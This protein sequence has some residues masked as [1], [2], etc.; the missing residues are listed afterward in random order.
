MYPVLNKEFGNPIAFV[1][2]LVIGLLGGLA[3]ALHE[4]KRY[5]RLKREHFL[6]R[7]FKNVTIY[8][9]YFAIIVALVIAFT[10]GIS[11]KQGL[12][13]YVIGPEYSQFIFHGDYPIIVAYALF[14]CG[15]VS[16]TLI[17]SKKVES[18]V[19]FNMISGRY[20]KPIE[21]D[22]I[23]MSI[24]LNDSTHIA[25]ELGEEKFFSFL[26]RFYL[27]LSPAI[28]AS[29]GQI[30]RYVGD[31]VIISW[32]V[33]SAAENTECLRTYF[34]AK[35]I[36]RRQKEYYLSNWGRMPAFKVALHA[37]TVIAGEVGDIKSQFV[38]HGEILQQLQTI[39]KLCKKE[40]APILI[41]SAFIEKTEIPSFYNLVEISSL[42]LNDDHSM[43]L[44]TV[45]QSFKEQLS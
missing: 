30:Y 9:L 32:P 14:F 36:L 41:S 19:M 40:G 20:R 27:D 8:T 23:F 15:L 10:Y 4:D 31:Q 33:K 29:N 13:Q 35:N 22:R 38:F 44:Y 16:F 18:R 3:I 12:I 39:E 34:S 6:L 45:E 42:D 11:S 1:N 37:G 7:F 25:E 28:M 5:L 26:N 24:D 17:M 43:A 21:E 2:G